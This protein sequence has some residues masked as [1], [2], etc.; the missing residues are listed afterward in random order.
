MPKGWV[1]SAG[2]RGGFE[3]TSVRS[4]PALLRS[5]RRAS[6][7]D[8]GGHATPRALHLRSSIMPE[9]LAM[10]LLRVRR[11][12]VPAAGS[13]C[14]HSRSWEFFPGRGSFGFPRRLMARRRTPAVGI[15][16]AVL[17]MIDCLGIR[18]EADEFVHQA[19][20]RPSVSMF[21]IAEL[22]LGRGRH[23]S[24]LRLVGLGDDDLPAR[25]RPSDQPR[26]RGLRLVKIGDS[27]GHS[28][29]LVRL[30]KIAPCLVRSSKSLANRVLAGWRPVR[31]AFRQGLDARGKA[32]LWWGAKEAAPSS[33]G[34]RRAMKSG[35]AD[36]WAAMNASKAASTSR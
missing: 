10:S 2:A 15:Y 9:P 16:I 4:G 6:R 28:V 30:T 32:A 34:R 5:V 29:S 12:G 11:S 31:A 13:R 27:C 21:T 3:R 23:Q 18:Q 19:G 14:Y 33:A 22:F 17:V 1:R 36:G 8:P 35:L 7:R 26:E 24:R 20:A 25:S